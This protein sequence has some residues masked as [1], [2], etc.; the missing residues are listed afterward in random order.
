[1]GEKAL[2]AGVYRVSPGNIPGT[3]ALNRSGDKYPVL[4][5]SI[6]SPVHDDSSAKLLFYCLRDSYFVAQ[7]LG[8]NITQ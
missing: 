2:K 3:V 1:V 4:S 5:Q 8:P 6:E 7:L